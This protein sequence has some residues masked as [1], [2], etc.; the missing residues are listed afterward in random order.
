MRNGVTVLY[1]SGTAVSRTP[2]LRADGVSAFDTL[3]D[4]ETISIRALYG[5]P[6][7]LR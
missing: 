5:T 6:L 4:D 1:H 2:A 7:A 3:C